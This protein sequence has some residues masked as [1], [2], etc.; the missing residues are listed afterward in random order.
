[1]ALEATTAVHL[2]EIT[3]FKTEAFRKSCTQDSLNFF[4]AT[5]NRLCAYGLIKSNINAAITKY[6]LAIPR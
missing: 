2:K 1:M 4:N 3:D 5:C 6:N